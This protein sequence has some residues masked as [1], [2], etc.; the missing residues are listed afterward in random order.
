[1]QRPE[2]L[3]D[4]MLYDYAAPGGGLSD[5][6]VVQLLLP[7]DYQPELFETE[8]FANA[9]AIA[10]QL[11]GDGIYYRGSHVIDKPPRGDNPTA[12]HQDEAF[13]DPAAKHEAIAIWIP[14]G[15]AP[16]DSG[17]MEFVPGSHAG[18]VLVHRRLGGDPSVHGLE[19][20]GEGVT[21]AVACPIRSGDVTVHHCRTVHGTGPNLSGQRR[22]SLVLNLAI[23]ARAL[24]EPRDFPWQRAAESDAQARR[25]RRRIE[26]P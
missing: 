1:M 21:G 11:L 10:R 3:A 2:P 12:W 25:A 9:A 24:A 16:R 8:L 5:P 4:G 14:L 6:R 22:R 20:D 23:A 26:L 17:C 15:D 18:D 19:L 13:W 7:F